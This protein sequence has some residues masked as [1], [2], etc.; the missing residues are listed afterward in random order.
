MAPGATRNARGASDRTWSRGRG[1]AE[2]NPPTTLVSP[3]RDDFGGING[4]S[5]SSSSG[6]SDDRRTSSNSSN[7]NNSRDLPA[8]VGRLAQD[9]EEIERELPALHSE[10]TRSQSRGL[11]IITSYVDDLLAYAMRGVEANKTLEEKA[12]EIGRAHDSLLEERLEK[13]REWLEEFERHGA[14][15]LDLIYCLT[16]ME[17]TVLGSPMCEDRAWG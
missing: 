6:S 9:L 5:S 2:G 15:L 3:G 11:T 17:R 16:L 13:E 14:L 7:S 12:V 4:S 10:R 8:L 1:G